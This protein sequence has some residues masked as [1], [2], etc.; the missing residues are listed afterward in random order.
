MPTEP[1]PIYWHKDR[2]RWRVH[3]PDGRK[4][5][6]KRA[7]GTPFAHCARWH[8]DLL[9]T[10]R[11]ILEAAPQR[12]GTG[13]FAPDTFNAYGRTYFKSAKFANLKPTTKRA[14]RC[15]VDQFLAE[16]GEK[17]VTKFERRHFRA[18]MDDLAGK[19]GAQRTLITVINLLIEPAIE[20]GLITSPTKGFDRPTLSK[21]G[22]LDWPE[23]I[24]A[25]YEEYFP[26]GHDARLAEGI[27]I[28][29]G[30]RRSDVVRMGKQHVKNGWLRHATEDRH[31]AAHPGLS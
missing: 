31:V 24:I 12:K 2:D 9:N 14:R 5:T 11:A 16:H 29:T 28:Y 19:P 25:Q 15:A 18:M 7:D 22:W 8:P 26:I 21:T 13:P 10:A 20:D 17:R 3:L 4:V 23:E 30:Q 27:G 1:H 6:L